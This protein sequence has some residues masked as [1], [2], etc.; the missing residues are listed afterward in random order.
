MVVGF[1]TRESK[2][3]RRHKHNYTQAQA[4][5]VMQS[6]L[7]ISHGRFQGEFSQRSWCTPGWIEQGTLIRAHDIDNLDNL[8]RA[9]D[10]ASAGPG[11][12]SPL[13]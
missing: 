13:P 4:F 10:S 3:N 12:L 2:H 9:Y 11:A 5:S 7:S 8:T 6:S 1:L